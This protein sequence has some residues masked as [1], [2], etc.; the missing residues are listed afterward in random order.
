[1]IKRW[2]FLLLLTGNS[3]LYSMTFDASRGFLPLYFKPFTHR[4]QAY[5]N[6]RVQPFFMRAER[7]HG[8]FDETSLPNIDGTYDQVQ[9]GRA[10]VAT[11]HPNLFPSRLRALTSIPWRREGHLDAEGIA[12]YLELLPG[13][14]HPSGFY[15]SSGMSFL[16]AHVNSAQEFCLDATN[17]TNAAGSRQALFTL[18]ERMDRELG[19]TP[20]LFRKTMFGDLDVYFRLG[21]FAEYICKVKRIDSGLKLGFIAP[22]ADDI[23]INNPASISL[24]GNKHWGVYLGLENEI[25][26]KED[27]V[28]GFQFRAIK[29]L[30]KTLTQRIPVDCEPTR[31]GAVVGPLHVDP[32]WTF[33]FNP[34]IS[35]EGLREGFGLKVQYTMVAH[36]KDTLSDMRRDKAVPVNLEP[37]RARSSW[38]SE[39]VTVGAFYDFNKNCEWAWWRPIISAYWDIPVDWKVSKRS[40]KTHSVSLMV[41]LNF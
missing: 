24:G 1:M 7:A 21:F 36:L 37:V 25:E 9:I 14:C 35:L 39:Y 38:G 30:S 23:N 17:A 26:L 19:V 2:Y 6:F 32:G 13:W 16:F 5:L 33:V 10:L 40:A 41:E 20:P 27:W 18:R 8:D 22:T 29:R 28:V 3:S 15:F 11:G 12:F 4:P 31:Y 34:Y